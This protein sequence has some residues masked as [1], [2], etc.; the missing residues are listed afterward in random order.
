M[1]IADVPKRRLLALWRRGITQKKTYYNLMVIY[2]R[3]NLTAKEP[4]VKSA[5]RYKHII[6]AN[7]Q[8]QNTK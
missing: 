3:A 4:I 2:E 1:L 5:Q 6:S 7:T 8:K